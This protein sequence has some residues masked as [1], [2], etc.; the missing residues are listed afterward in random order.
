MASQHDDDDH[1]QQ[2]VGGKE[3]EEE[4]NS[5]EEGKEGTVTFGWLFLLVS[6]GLFI[7]IIETAAAA[8]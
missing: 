5:I 3:K 6:R 7:G 1:D 2:E 8:I 4:R